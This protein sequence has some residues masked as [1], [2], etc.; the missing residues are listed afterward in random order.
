MQFSNTSTVKPRYL[1]T[2]LL[3]YPAY[4]SFNFK[5]FL[6]VHNKSE[7]V[8]RWFPDSIKSME[9]YEFRKQWLL[10]DS[11]HSLVITH[12]NHSHGTCLYNH[13]SMYKYI[14]HLNHKG[15]DQ[16]IVVVTDSALTKK[17]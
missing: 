4:K 11:C 16:T 15:T 5:I 13:P 7:L 17:R 10:I 3:T 8:I 2:K 9:A 14:E 6:K 12:D 1:Y